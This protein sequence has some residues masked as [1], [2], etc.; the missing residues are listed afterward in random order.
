MKS[1][2]EAKKSAE[3]GTVMDIGHQGEVVEVFNSSFLPALPKSE[4]GTVEGE[5]AQ[6]IAGSAE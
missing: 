2:K 3:V 5:R 4:G 1:E 6:E